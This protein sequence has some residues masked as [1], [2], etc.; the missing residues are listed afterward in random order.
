MKALN[1]TKTQ[2]SVQDYLLIQKSL[3]KIN[4]YYDSIEYDFFTESPQIILTNFILNII[5][6]F[7]FLFGISIYL[8]LIFIL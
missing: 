7:C 8:N 2:N 6:S 1:L 3:L 5:Y 4:I